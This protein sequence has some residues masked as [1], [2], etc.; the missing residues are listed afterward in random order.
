V[1]TTETELHDRSHV[2]PFAALPVVILA[3]VVGVAHCVATLF[4]R[5]YWFDEVYVAAT[6]RDHLDW[7]SADQP[8]LAPALAALIHAVAPGS[9]VAL[10]L[11]AIL[12]TAA[13][14]VVAA[15]IAR[16]LGC[17]RRAQVF[18]AAAQATALWTTLAGHWLTPYALEPLQWMSLVWLM[19]RWQRVRDDRLLLVIGVIAGLAVLTKFQVMLLC[20]VLLVAI[21]V[22]G[23]RDL[24]RR[25]MLW[26]GALVALVIASPTVIW[27]QLHGW[28]QLRM[29]RVVAGEADALYGG[30][31]GIAVELLL[32]A[33][34]AGAFLA[35]YGLVR[36]LRTDELRPYRYLGVTFPVLWVV[37]VIAEGRP[38][39][40]VGLYAPLAAAGALGLQRRRE[41][42]RTARRW[43]LWPA[44]VACG[45]LAIGTLVVSVTVAR[46]D[47]GEGIAQRTAEVLRGLPADQR[48]RTVVY[49]E[50]Y[51]VAAFL[52]GFADLYGL[53][54]AYSGNRG[55]GYF[56]EP[57]ADHDAVL[58]VGRDPSSLSPY[59]TATSEVG[60]IGD[61]MHAFLL[62]GLREPWASVWPRLRTLTVS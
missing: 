31:G 46:S 19:I 52:D 41:S 47:V 22:C 25:P 40:L 51:I 28:P 53:P 58:Y 50:S 11:P 34:L 36:L 37:F 62:T 55:Y 54:E 8:P 33:G 9:L 30:R 10:R 21:A 60:D 7:G 27:Q 44:W 35:L 57:P 56:A 39:Y 5:G 61:D 38:Y 14:V 42:G 2:E 12:A 59:F 16:E 45:A 15:L 18:V 3:V 17:D 48:D 1:A 4:S 20:L 13:A 6:G 26:V 23:P 29:T 43:L 24:L 49:G 32:F